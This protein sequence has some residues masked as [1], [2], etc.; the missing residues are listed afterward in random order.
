[1]ELGLLDNFVGV[2]QLEELQ[3]NFVLVVL[4]VEV[5]QQQH[6]F[7]VEQMGAQL[8]DYPLAH[9]KLELQ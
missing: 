8:V 9:N 3:H 6:N 4:G 5:G 2:E 7:V 1:M